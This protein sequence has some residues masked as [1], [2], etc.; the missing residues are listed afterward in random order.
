MFALIAERSC[1]KKP[2]YPVSNSRIENVALIGYTALHYAAERGHVTTVKLLTN[3]GATELQNNDGLSP[4]ELASVNCRAKVVKWFISGRDRRRREVIETLELLGATYAT[5]PTKQ[6][7]NKAFELISAAMRERFVECGD[8]IHKFARPPIKAYG[9]RIECQTLEDLVSIKGQPRLIQQEGLIMRERLLRSDNRLVPSHV[10]HMACSMENAGLYEESLELWRHSA[11]LEQRNGFSV[12][13]SFC[14]VAHLLFLMTES[15]RAVSFNHLEDVFNNILTETGILLNKVRT[16]RPRAQTQ[17]LCGMSNV[18]F[19]EL[20]SISLQ[21]ELSDK[22][23]GNL[24]AFVKK[25]INLDPPTTEGGTLLHIAVNGHLQ[26]MAAD[27]LV[28]F[29]LEAQADVK[30]PDNLGNTPLHAAASAQHEDSKEQ[31]P[32]QAIVMSLLKYGA[33]ITAKNKAGIKAREMAS[34]PRIKLL[35]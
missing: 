23:E 22:E 1:E 11:K 8:A 2:V 16:G 32:Q 20:L 35:L 21:M 6:D 30:Y 19:L 29:I 33:D 18:A 17:R 4:S 5:H 7:V 9:Y 3:I 26:R 14:K 27:R 34:C 13:E 25:I 12:L 31:C 28:K 15:K 24:R 10:R